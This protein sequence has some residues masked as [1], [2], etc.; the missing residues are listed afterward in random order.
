[1]G[2]RKIE[3]RRPNKAADRPYF[4][5]YVNI[6]QA[7]Y[8]DTPPERYCPC[9]HFEYNTSSKRSFGSKVWAMYCQKGTTNIAPFCP[10]VPPK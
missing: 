9:G 2:L 5:N 8:L 6:I 7:T 4:D 10:T 3:K 1:M